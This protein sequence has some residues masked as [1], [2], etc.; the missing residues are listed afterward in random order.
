[1]E[2][3]LF[4]FVLSSFFSIKC[5]G[6]RGDTSVCKCQYYSSYNIKT[7]RHKL[8]SIRQVINKNYGNVIFIGYRSFSAA[9]VLFIIKTKGVYKAF[10]YNL[11]K[12]SS[13]VIKGRKVSEI[14]DR[15]LKDTNA[16]KNSA[17]IKQQYISH[18]FSFFVS[19]NNGKN[20]YELCYSQV[21]TVKN[22]HTGQLFT[23]YLDNFR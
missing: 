14:A 3:L 23:Y 18:D 6:Q 16:V 13:Q 10:F 21:L 12:G 15:I 7:Y 1:M 17:K 4:I 8:D 11:V 2:K 5:L 19:Y 22:N 9:N 20:I